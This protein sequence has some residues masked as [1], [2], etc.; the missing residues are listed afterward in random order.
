M[1]SCNESGR[2]LVYKKIISKSMHSSCP[3]VAYTPIEETIELF[4]K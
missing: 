1:I 3:D 2:V 4:K